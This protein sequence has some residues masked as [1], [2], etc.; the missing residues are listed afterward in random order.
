MVRKQ[1][2]AGL[3]G[4]FLISSTTTSWAW[5]GRTTNPSSGYKA[6]G[7]ITYYRS[8][9][10]TPIE[11]PPVNGDMLAIA[12]ESGKLTIG[13]ANIALGEF[14]QGAFSPISTRKIQF[15]SSK[16]VSVPV[17]YDKGQNHMYFRTSIIKSILKSKTLSIIFIGDHSP[18]PTTFNVQGLSRFRM[19]LKLYGCS[20]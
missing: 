11:T 17:S 14:T 4:I 15:D 10:N 5:E 19:P 13:V 9:D 1:L 18:N 16:Y 6:F 20:I 3:V 8:F 12:C 7:V 2:A